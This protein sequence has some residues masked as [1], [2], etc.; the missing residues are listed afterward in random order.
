MATPEDTPLVADVMLGTLV[1][2]LRMCGYD[3][4]YALDRGVESDEAVRAIAEDEG[5]VLLTRDVALGERT[6]EAV[7]LESRAVRDQLRELSARGYDLC[8]D[9]PTRC[10]RCNG[11]L[12]RLEATESAP[13]F[14]PDPADRPVWECIECGQPFW[15]GS[16]WDD[17]AATLHEVGRA[18]GS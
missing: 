18:D 6:A 9:V 14:A 4:A 11:R 1:T 5:R 16:H 17:V 10:A 13:A 3:T 12:R 2:Y 8:L 15:R 7:V